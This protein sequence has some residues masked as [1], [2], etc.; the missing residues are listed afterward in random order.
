M[1]VKHIEAELEFLSFLKLTS[2]AELLRTWTEFPSTF[3]RIK[4]AHTQV[5]RTHK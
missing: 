4:E 5:M 1:N 2:G 3:S